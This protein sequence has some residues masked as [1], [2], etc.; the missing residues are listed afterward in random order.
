MT[1]YRTGRMGKI[2]AAPSEI[3]V[4]D[5]V[6]NIRY[7]YWYLCSDTDADRTF[8]MDPDSFCCCFTL[9]WLFDTYLPVYEEKFF[10]NKYGLADSFFVYVRLLLVKFNFQALFHHYCDKCGKNVF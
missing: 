5:T 8:D 7:W 10:M 2:S 1:E 4:M 9:H 3:H 6:Q